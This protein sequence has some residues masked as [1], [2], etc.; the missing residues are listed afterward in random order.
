MARG[1]GYSGA[2]HVAGA[3]LGVAHDTPD[4]QAALAAGRG[5]V[6]DIAA[7]LDGHADNVAATLY[8]GIVVTAGG[9]VVHIA[10]SLDPDVVLWIPPSTTSTAASRTALPEAVTF[11][12]AVFNVGRAALLVAALAVGDVTALRQA[13]EDRLHQSARLASVPGSR[14]ALA[15]GLANGAWC[16][17]L[18]G[19]GPT[20]AFLAEPGAGN[21]V[22]E[23]LPEGGQSKIVAIDRVGVTVV[24][25]SGDG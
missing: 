3:S 23:G 22:V 1:M 10:T 5:R 19:S 8:G 11:A 6:L 16:G 14:A 24:A 13:T 4:P 2:M 17:W 20:V 15:A 25:S 18:S 21:A 12:D 7:D 9:R